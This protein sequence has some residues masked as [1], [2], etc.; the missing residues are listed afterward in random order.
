MT[1]RPAIQFNVALKGNGL[2]LLYPQS[3]R[4]DLDLNLAMTGTPQ[5]SWLQGQVNVNRVSFTPDFDL[6][7]FIAQFS[8]VATPPPTQGFADNLNLNIAVRSTSELN[9]V[10]PGVSIQGDANLRVIGTATDP[11]IVGR[12]NL[13]GGDLIFL[14]N[15]YVVQGG[16]IAFVNS[17]ETDAGGEPAGQDHDSAIQHCDALPWSAGPPAHRLHFRSFASSGRH[18]SSARVW[19]NGRGF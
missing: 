16:T 3:V 15:R 13:T 18:H 5:K 10:S 2:R 4:S 17:I 11:V 14:G 6:S 8:G 19:Q 1:Y 9:A 7:Q 12:T